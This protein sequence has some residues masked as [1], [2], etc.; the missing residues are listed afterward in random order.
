VMRGPTRVFVVGRAHAGLTALAV[1]TVISGVAAQQPGEAEERIR[2]GDI[3]VA[4]IGDHTVSVFDGDSGAFRG[5]ASEAGAGGLEHPTGIAFGP[6][7][8]LYVASS[9]NGRILRYDGATGSFLETFAEGAPLKR[10]FSLIFGPAGDL[11][12]SSGATVL[13]YGPDGSFIGYAAR[14]SSLEQPIGLAFGQDGLLYVANSTAPSVTRFDPSTGDRVDV[15]AADSLAFPSD[16]AFGPD[17]DLYVSNAS[18][19]RV[20]RFD[21]ITGVFEAVVATLPDGGVPMGL[22]FRDTRLIIGDFARSRLFF[23]D[24]V[25][26]AAAAREVASEGL[27]R[28]ENVAV[29]P[30]CGSGCSGS[31]RALQPH[32][33][34]GHLRVGVAKRPQPSRHR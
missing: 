21:G 1:A 16:V 2:P 23:L 25:A 32:Y 12:V 24:A 22:A 31:S 8:D 6:D 4:N 33:G 11:F 14:D 29:R 20:V 7:G 5:L 28:P 17:G 34:R 19:H 15:F 26:A 18:A 9:G 30:P 27:Q 10:P 13:R 3:V